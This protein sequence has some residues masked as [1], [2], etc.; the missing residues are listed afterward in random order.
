LLKS[1]NPPETEIDNKWF[2]LAKK[3]LEDINSAKVKLV[4]GEEVFQKI[5]KR[6][7]E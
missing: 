3:R 7:T 4:N 5:K 6:F 1:L 2:A